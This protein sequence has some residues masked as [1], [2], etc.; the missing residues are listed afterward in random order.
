[1]VIPAES[2]ELASVGRLVEW[3]ADEDAK[4]LISAFGG[5]RAEET[6]MLRWVG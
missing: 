3:L 4:T 2:L 6:G 1:L 5:Y